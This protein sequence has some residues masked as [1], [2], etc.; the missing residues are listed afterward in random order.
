MFV[1]AFAQSENDHEKFW[2]HLNGGP[3]ELRKD[4]VAQAIVE[5]PN[6][7]FVWMIHHLNQSTHYH[8]TYDGWSLHDA[9]PAKKMAVR[10]AKA[11]RNTSEK[12]WKTSILA[13]IQLRDKTLK[14]DPEGNPITIWI[15]TRLPIQV[16]KEVLGVE[17]VVEAQA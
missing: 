11:P 5:N 8:L 4:G 1:P 13:S 17:D 16:M 3:V 2:A 7:A 10:L 14:I 9:G 15:T 12:A 6:A